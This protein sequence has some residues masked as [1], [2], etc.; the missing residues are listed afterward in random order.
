[1]IRLPSRLKFSQ[2]FSGPAVL[3]PPAAP[4]AGTKDGWKEG[5][6]ISTSPLGLSVCTQCPARGSRCT[7]WPEATMRASSGPDH[8][9]GC[10]FVRAGARGKGVG[11]AQA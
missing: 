10:R 2:F 3:Q 1:M 11:G 9:C 5:A 6:M 4:Q 8:L 7:R